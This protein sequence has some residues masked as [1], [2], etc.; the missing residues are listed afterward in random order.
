MLLW[1]GGRPQ[2]TSPHP[3]IT[4]SGLFTFTLAL[5]QALVPE[6]ECWDDPAPVTEGDV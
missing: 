1:S 5:S 4:D 2:P 6:P 3:P